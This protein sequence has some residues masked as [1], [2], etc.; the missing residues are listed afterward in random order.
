MRG[1]NSEHVMM[2]VKEVAE[3]LNVSS[4]LVYSLIARGRIACERYGVG[5]GTIRVPR[6]ALD[7][8]RSMSRP[9]PAR[10][11]PPTNSPRGYKELDASRLAQ[12]WR[13]RG[14]GG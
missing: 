13:H 11:P 5:R 12:A 6:V 2:T 8:F 1:S 10:L 9:A 4:A 3:I 7:E 14:V